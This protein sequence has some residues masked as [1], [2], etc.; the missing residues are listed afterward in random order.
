MCGRS[1]TSQSVAR[2]PAVTAWSDVEAHS[3]SPDDEAAS[4]A[5]IAAWRHGMGCYGYDQDRGSL[6][7]NVSR[8]GPLTA[9]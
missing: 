6:P 2:V 5:A 8:D 3:K 4:T 1:W 7:M 9:E